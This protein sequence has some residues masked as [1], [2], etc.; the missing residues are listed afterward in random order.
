VAA[1]SPAVGE[2]AERRGRRIVLIVGF[3]A[4]PA[5]ALIFALLP[6][7]YLLVAAQALD[8]VSA[9]AFGVMV[10]LVAADLT[11]GSGRYNLVQGALGLV[12]AGGATASTA[13]AGL[14]ADRFGN[15]TAFALLGL[16]GLGSVLTIMVLMPETR[17]REALA[18]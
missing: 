12:A 5:R 10:P 6:D 13:L 18:G 7:A 1:M 16:A 14:I 9:A 2:W 4:L 3:A 17:R 11:R 15:P 8:G